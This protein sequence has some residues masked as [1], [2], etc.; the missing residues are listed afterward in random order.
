[1][2]D[3]STGDSLI[4]RRVAKIA[5][6]RSVTIGLAIT[7][8]LLSLVGAVVIRII[9]EHDFPSIGLAVWWSLQT[10]T[11]VGYGD[12]VPTT[13]IGRFVGAIELVLGVSFLT[14]LT[15]GVTSTVVERSRAGAEEANRARRE[16]D[17]RT[18]VEA[19][20]ETREAIAALERRLETIESKLTT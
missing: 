4:D 2:A 9:D 17:T 7:F 15:A 12:V 14:F 6:A 19:L 3:K 13:E 8:V 20:A 1:M 18:I 16:R 10:V 5:N 11:T